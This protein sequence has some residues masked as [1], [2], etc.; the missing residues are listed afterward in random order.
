MPGLELDT[1]Q[2]M[3]QL[4]GYLESPLDHLMTASQD[5]NS[6]YRGVVAMALGNRRQAEAVAP[7]VARLTESNPLVLLAASSALGKIGGP[8]AV[9]GLVELLKRPGTTSEITGIAAL[10]LIRGDAAADDALANLASDRALA[11]RA[12]A[13]I[14]IENKS[15]N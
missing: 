8:D 4:L 5:P 2:G 10:G 1:R 11:V 14:A 6:G 9:K 13:A 12:S 3:E 7:L 15:R